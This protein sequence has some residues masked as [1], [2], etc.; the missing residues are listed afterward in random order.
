MHPSELSYSSDDEAML[1]DE[2]YGQS[3]DMPPLV[4]SKEEERSLVR[5]S[6]ASFAGDHFPYS[7]YRLCP[8]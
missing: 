3:G 4:L 7:S 6:T 5:D 2:S 8:L 1:I